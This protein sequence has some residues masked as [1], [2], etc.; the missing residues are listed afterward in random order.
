ML[1]RFLGAELILTDPANGF[2]GMIGGSPGSHKIQGMGPGFIPEVLDTLV[3][4]QVVTVSMEEATAIADGEEAGKEG[5]PA[6]RYILWCKRRCLRQD[7]SERRDLGQD[8][9]YHIP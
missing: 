1:L 8:D 3:I 7:R 9:R 2:K 6:G 4:D 5:G